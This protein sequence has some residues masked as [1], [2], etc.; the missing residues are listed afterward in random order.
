MARLSTV[1]ALCRL[2]SGSETT[3]VK[4]LQ[5]GL[6]EAEGCFQREFRTEEKIEAQR[7]SLQAKEE[8]EKKKSCITLV[9]SPRQPCVTPGKRVLNPGF[10]VAGSKGSRGLPAI[11][12]SLV[13]SFVHRSRALGLFRTVV[14]VANQQR[15]QILQRSHTPPS[16]IPP[17]PGR[18][19]GTGTGCPEALRRVTRNGGEACFL[20]SDRQWWHASGSYGRHM[21]AAIRARVCRIP[22]HAITVDTNWVRRPREGV[23]GK[24][25]GPFPENFL[26]SLLASALLPNGTF[27]VLVAAV[28]IPA[29]PEEL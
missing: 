10:W 8:G 24:G 14:T 5:L 26:G 13:S 4:A 18:P 11:T 19:T 15:G 27:R 20:R 22:R 23:R 25:I 21:V 28:G 9:F 3:S 16:T 7:C 2:A 1:G 29:A 12:I 17:F 6:E